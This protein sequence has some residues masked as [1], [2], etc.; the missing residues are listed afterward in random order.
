MSEE[1]P[2]QQNQPEPEAKAKP[3]VVRRKHTRKADDPN[4]ER[5]RKRAARAAKKEKAKQAAKAE[6]VAKAPNSPSKLLKTASPEYEKTRKQNYRQKQKAEEEKR[7]ALYRKK[8]TTSTNGLV[9]LHKGLPVTDLSQFIQQ[10][11]QLELEDWDTRIRKVIEVHTV[12]SFMNDDLVM[13]EKQGT[14]VV[15]VAANKEFERTFKIFFNKQPWL[16]VK[17]SQLPDSGYGLFVARPNGFQAHESIGLY[18]GRIL[19]L[20]ETPS[21]YAYTYVPKKNE[22]DEEGCHTKQP[23]FIIRHGKVVQLEVEEPKEKVVDAEGGVKA[24]RE[25]GFPAYFGIHMANDPR[26]KMCTR[27]AKEHN[28]Y[29]TEE[30]E[31]R[32]SRKMDLGEELYLNYRFCDMED[33]KC[34]GCLEVEAMYTKERWGG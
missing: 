16:E 33:C 14:G 15:Q 23:N 1:E 28:F 32:V 2:T 30:L 8:A 21:E 11:N 18:Y 13:R 34:H 29:V 27:T 25:D 4:Y 20:F 22:E 24:G 9:K 12:I 31:A 5:D 26:F 10:L 19:G 6:E 17:K 7:N 3:F